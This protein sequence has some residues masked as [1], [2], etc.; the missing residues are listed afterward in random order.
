MVAWV[1]SPLDNVAG[2]GCLHKKPFGQQRITLKWES[3]N[4]LNHWT[5]VKTNLTDILYLCLGRTGIMTQSRQIPQESDF[6]RATKELGRFFFAKAS[7][8]HCAHRGGAL[9]T[10]AGD[11]LLSLAPANKGRRR[12]SSSF[13]HRP[14]SSLGSLGLWFSSN[15]N[16]ISTGQNSATSVDHFIP[17]QFNHRKENAPLPLGNQALFVSSMHNPSSTSVYFRMILPLRN[18]HTKSGEIVSIIHHNRK[19]C[20][21]LIL[22]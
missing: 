10:E 15:H 14:I 13:P 18:I 3:I 17:H 21:Q 1:A 4:H 5:I 9:K 2:N 12:N 20:S 7:P 16:R 19:T 8:L 11:I 6:S 22:S